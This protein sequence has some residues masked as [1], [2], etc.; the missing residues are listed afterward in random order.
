[1]V[2]ALAALLLTTATCFAQQSE[3]T[4]R[5][6]RPTVE[7]M[8]R[9][10][11]ERLTDQLKLNEKQAEQAYAAVLER[12]RTTEALHKQM[13]AA[14]SAEAEQMKSILTTDQFVK[15]SQMQ[16]QGRAAQMMKNGREKGAPHRPQGD[17]AARM[18]R[19]GN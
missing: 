16:R 6:E 4:G 9:Q 15:W 7:Q 11:V 5:R 18:R 13:H 8:A 10:T 17:A 12:L 2:T 14:K 1:M 3:Q 19:A